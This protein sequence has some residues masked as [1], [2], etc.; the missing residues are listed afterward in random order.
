MQHCTARHVRRTPEEL[1]LS[2]SVVIVG[3]GFSGAAMAVQLARRSA[4]PLAIT[5]VEPRETVGPGVAYSTLDPDHR[6]NGSVATHLIDPGDPEALQRWCIAQR[7]ATRDPEARAANGQ[8][9]LRRADF[10]AFVAETVREHAHMP[11]GTTIRH[12]RDRAFDVDED[13]D[14]FIVRMETGAA[15][16]ARLVVVATGNGGVRLPPPFAA[17]RSH[18]A[19]IADPADL[20]RVRAI[21]PSARVLLIGAGLTALDIVSTLVRHGHRGGITIVSRHG[22]RPRA[23]RPP[24]AETTGARVQARISGDVPAFAADAVTSLALSRALRRR[25]R[26]HE[27]S[28]GDWYEPFDALRD[29]VW[30]VWP[31]LDAEEKKRF[32]RW[33]RPWYDIHR[34]RAPPQNDAIARDAEARGAIRFLRARLEGAHASETTLCV[35]WIGHEGGSR[36]TETFDAVVNCTGLD[37]AC[38]ADE[39]PFLASLLRKG[40]LQRDA[41]GVGFAVDAQCRPIG[42]DDHAHPRLRVVGPPTAGTFGDPLGTLFIAPQ[43]ARVVLGMLAGLGVR[44]D[45]DAAAPNRRT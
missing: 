2:A 35:T 43:I 26:Q 1:R 14:G 37:P 33:L 19:L 25:I 6:L 12:L 31:R 44:V 10:G 17:L 23:Q 41:T 15:L 11:N 39:N 29:V 22:L 40:L 30:K 32:L 21:A 9:Y 4:S 16:S 42:I 5:I 36:V 45:E 7:I 8:T 38:G 34:F 27:A 3:G 18:R 20:A 24:G 13:G 28:G